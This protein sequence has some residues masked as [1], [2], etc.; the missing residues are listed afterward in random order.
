MATDKNMTDMTV[1]NPLSH[2]LKFAVPLL[3]GNIFQQFYSMVDSIVVGRYVGANA[4]AAVGTCNSSVF[5]FFSLTSGLA[6][7]MGIIVA[8]YFGAKND[9][10]IKKTITSGAYVLL[11][12]SILVG[13]LAYCLAPVILH[14]LQTPEEIIG[15][16]I[17]YMRTSCFGI[18]G[19]A[20]YNEIASV[21]RALGDSKTPLYFLF[22]SSITNIVL[23]L[24]LVLSFGMGVFGVALA[25]VISQYISFA[26]CAVFAVKKVSYFKLDKEDLRP[27]KKIIFESFRLGIPIALQNSMIAISMMVLQG[28]VN[29][30]GT[31]VMAAYT[32]VG[33][34]EMIVQ[35][36]YGSL[37]MAITNYSGQNIGAGRLDRV[38]Q[39]FK[40]STVIALVFSLML[41]P[42]AYIF[43]ETIIRFFVTEPAVIEIGARALRINSICYFALGMIYVPRAV[44]NGC[45]DTGFSMINGI[46]EVACRIGYSNILT[47]IPAI[48]YWGIWFTTCATYVTTAIICC[49]R[50]FTGKWKDKVIK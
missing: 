32:V 21:L 30:F 34:V 35:Q 31:S 42:I 37:S 47:R 22:L 2:I 16:S 15:D 25:T 45:G 43:G 5:L 20:L 44:L 36:P 48:G 41:L 12:M 49:I 46:T 4:L 28:I 29:A 33:K 19:I 3:V 6:V 17:T 40:I 39:G 7:G 1:G 26:A 14:L 23:D 8:Q 24:L 50:Y 10:Q 11:G 18:I 38:K 27:Q 9:T 13:V